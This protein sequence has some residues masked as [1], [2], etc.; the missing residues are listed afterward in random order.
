MTQH[1]TP[2]RRRLKKAASAARNAPVIILGIGAIIS[3]DLY[4]AAG[5]FQTNTEQATVFG[6]HV[7][8]AWLEAI[9]S[10]LCGLLAF[11]GGIAASEMKA[12][13]RPEQQSRAFG[14]RV[15]CTLLMVAPV[16]YLGN[17]LAFS[18]QKAEWREYHGSEAYRADLAQAND[19]MIDSMARRDAAINL[20]KAIE[21]KVA[22][23]DAFRWLFAAFLYAVVQAAAAVFYTAK[24]ET[25][26][27]AKERIAKDRAARSMATREE[28]RKA[29]EQEQRRIK[30]AAA[31][32]G[33]GW[34][35]KTA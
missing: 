7:G 27:A 4:A 23:F 3:Y 1:V 11:M 29:A 5:V 25:P 31:Q 15:L 22:K 17:A 2:W 28:N 35:R 34:G 21:P 12:D 14:A 20:T 19:D 10:L 13:P 30:A 24:P 6:F 16:T 26:A 32:S 9:G 8:L 18:A 33:W